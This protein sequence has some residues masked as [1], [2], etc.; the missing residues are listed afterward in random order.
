MLNLYFQIS[1]LHQCEKMLVALEL[2]GWLNEASLA[3]QAV[4]QCY[5]LLA[6]LTHFQIPALPIVQVFHILQL[7]C[8]RDGYVCI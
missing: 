3:L 5:G 8:Q 4:V 1:R 7:Q 6:P 2:A